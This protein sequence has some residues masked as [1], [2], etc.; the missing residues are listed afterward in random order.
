MYAPPPCVTAD[1]FTVIPEPICFGNRRSDWA[2]AQINGAP[3]PT[4]L[5]GPCFDAAGNLWVTDIPWG[6]LLKITP[7]GE[8]SVGAEY[9]GQPNGLKFLADGRGL[10]ADFKNGLM[11]FDPATGAVEP[12]LVR[13]LLEP[14]RG[15]ND[16]TVASNGDL[17][18]TD[19]GMS[20]LHDPYGRV[21]RLR[22]DGGLELLLD[23]IPS[24]N[25]L[26]LNKAE[27]ALMVAVTR[28]NAIWRVPL[29]ADGGVTKVGT[30]IQMSG[31]N[32]P[33]GLAMDEDDNIAVC[34]VGMGCAWLFDDIGEPILRIRS[35]KGR[36][37]TNCAYGGADRKSLFITESGSGAILRAELPA[38]GRMLH[39]RPA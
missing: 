10:I 22:V 31:G 19:Q 18:F 8:V 24:P 13:R 26:V 14:F 25:G 36:K 9:D 23:R 3:T 29:T 20:G 28:A 5:E 16:L 33:D 35:P 1:V 27:T 11:V 6:R 17:Y 30:F 2:D 37:V 32:G 21:Y 34:H 4:Y 38:P 39:A 12:Y 7:G 15:C